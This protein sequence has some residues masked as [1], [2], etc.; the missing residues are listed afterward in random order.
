MLKIWAKLFFPLFLYVRLL[1]AISCRFFISSQ[2]PSNLDVREGLLSAGNV[3]LMANGTQECFTMFKQ[4]ITIWKYDPVRDDYADV[5]FQGCW[6]GNSNECDGSR[7]VAHGDIGS[8]YLKH[9]RYCCCSS[10]FCNDNFSY[11]YVPKP[12]PEVE[13][14]IVDQVETDELTFAVA[15]CASFFIVATLAMTYLLSRAC[16]WSKSV[17]SLCSRDSDDK[18]LLSDVNKDQNAKTK[19]VKLDDV[20]LSRVLYTGRYSTVWLAEL[21]TDGSPVALKLYASGLQRYGINEIR[22]LALPL[23]KHENMVKY[24]ASADLTGKAREGQNIECWLLTDYLPN[25]SL[26]DYLSANS[27]SWDAM[28]K[29]AS[30]VAKGVA[31]L[32]AEISDGDL[33]KPA[34]AH[35]DINSRNVLVKSDGTCALC[36][37]AFAVVLE[38]LSQHTGRRDASLAEVGTVR[39]MAPELLEGAANLRDPETTLKQLD[40]YAL[41]LVLWE[42]VSRCEDMY[43]LNGATVPAYELPYAKDVSANPSLEEMQRV[44]CKNKKRPSFPTAMYRPKGGPLY[45]LRELIEDCWDQ[46][47]DARITALCAQERLAELC[48]ISCPAGPME[49]HEFGS[50]VQQES[51]NSRNRRVDG[52]YIHQPSFNGDSTTDTSQTDTSGFASVGLGSSDRG[53]S[54]ASSLG[55]QTNRSL[56]SAQ[57]LQQFESQ[58]TESVEHPSSTQDSI[59]G[60]EEGLSNQIVAQDETSGDHDS[61]ASFGNSS[62]QLAK[63]AVYPLLLLKSARICL[64]NSFASEESDGCAPVSNRNHNAVDQ[65]AIH[66]SQSPH[67]IISLPQVETNGTTPI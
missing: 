39:Y 60:R 9:S 59:D 58:H 53:R 61:G 35:R 49:S 18:L 41:G 34:V 30:S 3:S 63:D 55:Y 52:A 5:L 20:K 13:M 4:C 23:M 48:T 19:S 64:R 2:L 50:V 14:M 47:S 8:T 24:L 33:Y 1:N 65:A 21:K 28:C 37:F 44:V 25:G 36:D 6:K 46:D 16:S 31:Y 43:A 38:T 67:V 11:E 26:M 27:L 40:V 66:R 32:H 57:R 22:I 17:L 45:T 51:P 12:V 7:C 29:L 54:C 62:R 15:I 56:S 42:I 10:S